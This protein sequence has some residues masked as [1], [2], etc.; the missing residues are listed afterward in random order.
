[1]EQ[2][3]CGRHAVPRRR[4]LQGGLAAAAIGAAGAEAGPRAARAAEAAAPRAIDIHAHYYPQDYLDVLAVEGK[5]YGYEVETL[6]D[7]FAIGPVRY[8]AKFTALGR[9]LAEM[10]EIGVEMHALSLTSPMVYFAEPPAQERLARAW[11]DAASAAHQAHPRRFVAL[12][13]L[14]MG[15]PDRALGELERASTLPGIRGVYLGTNI[16]GRDL[17]D[18]AFAPVFARI[19]ALELPIFLHPLNTVGGDRLGKTYYLWN[20]IGNPLDTAIAAAH[21]IFGGVLDRHPRLEIALPHSGGVMP[22][23]MGR[24]DRGGLT[25]PEL[26]HMA[27]APSAYLRRFTYDTVC[28]SEPVLRFLI[29]QVGIERVMLGSD[30]CFDMGYARPVDIVDGLKLD[31]AQRAQILRGT[32]ARLLKV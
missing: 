6:A 3:C 4:V 13:T 17:D 20:L 12:A 27:R 1:M 2:D 9:R 18:P 31:D 32:A 14:P 7:G 24:W 30:Y 10:D 19:E 29:A 5:R 28:H 16:A 23:L 11:N 26:K 25:R 8:A 15:D 22:M 21:L